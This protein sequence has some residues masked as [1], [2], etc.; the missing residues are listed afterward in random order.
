MVSSAIQNPDEI[1][2]RLEG[3]LHVGSTLVP[4]MTFYI[5]NLQCLFVGKYALNAPKAWC[6]YRRRRQSCT[7]CGRAG[8]HIPAEADATMNLPAAA[9]MNPP[10]V[11]KMNLSAAAIMCLLGRMQRWPAGGQ[12]FLL[13]GRLADSF[14]RAV[15]EKGTQYAPTLLKLSLLNTLRGIMCK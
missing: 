2:C 13:Q 8:Y 11:A 15:T 1:L 14:L 5:S 12:C 9:T 7:R 6:T 3:H 4:E 10:A